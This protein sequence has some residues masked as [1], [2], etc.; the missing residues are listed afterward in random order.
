MVLKHTSSYWRAACGC[1]DISESKGTTKRFFLHMCSFSHLQKRTA[2]FTALFTIPLTDKLFSNDQKGS[3]VTPVTPVTP[4]EAGVGFSRRPFHKRG[5]LLVPCFFRRI[6]AGW[7]PKIR[8]NRETFNHGQVRCGAP[9]ALPVLHPRCFAQ[10]DDVSCLAFP[11]HVWRKYRGMPSAAP[12]L[13]II[14]A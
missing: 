1:N 11:L 6:S 5:C 3:P 10:P 9:R 12:V 13:E 7:A 4:D 8:V 14:Q 2:S